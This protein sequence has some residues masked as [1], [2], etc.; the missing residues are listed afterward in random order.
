MQKDTEP[1]SNEKRQKTPTKPRVTE[2]LDLRSSDLETIG[3]DQKRQLEILMKL[4]RKKKK[5][6]VIAGAGISVGAGIPDFRSSNGL[7]NTLRTAKNS[8]KDLFD[9]SVYKDD[10]L[11]ASFHDMVRTLHG[12]AAEAEPTEFHQLLATLA[13]EGRLLRLYSQNVDCIDTRLE[14]LK[15]SVPLQSKGPWPTTI[16][17]HGGL[18]KMNC[19]KCGWVGPME[20][21]LFVGAKPPDCR[22]C[23]EME[24]VRG[25]AG[26]RSLGVGKLRPR[27]VL[28]NEFHPDAEA[29]GAVTAA[30]IRARPDALI[31]VGTSLKVPGVK[32][33][34]QEMCKSV[35]GFR[36][37]VSV[38]VNNHDPPLAKDYNFDLVVRG[39]C[40]KV[41]TLASLPR[42]DSESDSSEES[43][44][45]LAPT[46]RRIHSQVEVQIIQTQLPS[47]SLSP[48][49]GADCKPKPG[50]KSKKRTATAMAS[51]AME[52]PVKKARARA[53]KTTTAKNEPTQPV[54]KTAAAT[55]KASFRS[56]KRAP[57]TG[58]KPKRKSVVAR[59]AVKSAPGIVRLAN[60]PTTSSVSLPSTSIPSP[61]RGIISVGS[62]LN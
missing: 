29:I 40:E 22:E 62:L 9:A 23:L 43:F 55:I 19:S 48:D 3:T 36:G 56:V 61:M 59:N 30:D 26:K 8:G 60:T 35:R 38:W 15:T 33:I 53:T 10:D 13:T 37:G 24:S 6:V 11:T 17:V 1:A 45:E 52:K 14:P 54:N 46:E 44:V 27:I 51:L 57:P 2:F 50:P 25:I 47:P 34:V 39:D 16:Q 41:A 42:W 18:E 4:L 20:P 49:P 58:T 32:R 21:Q 7:F 31:V 5:I 12:M 28:Y